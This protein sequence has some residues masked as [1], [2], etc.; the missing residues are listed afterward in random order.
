[1][2]ESETKSMGLDETIQNNWT[3]TNSHF[4]KQDPVINVE[5]IG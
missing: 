3:K 4:T 2:S 1:M 5:S